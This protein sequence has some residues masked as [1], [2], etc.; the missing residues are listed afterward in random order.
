MTEGLEPVLV[1]QLIE[2]IVRQAIAATDAEAGTVWLVHSDRA[3][4][5]PAAAFGPNSKEI[6]DFCL[7]PGEG[8][9]G[10][11]IGGRQ[12]ILL[13][14]ASE[15]PAWAFYFD[16]FSGFRT[17]SV[18]CVPLYQGETPVGA[19]QLLNK[20][21]GHFTREDLV[22]ARGLAREVVALIKRGP[23]NDTGRA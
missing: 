21:G 14:E 9:V 11:A 17:G 22:L 5:Y 2:T 19:L 20:R 6:T 3:V 1:K 10:R 13:D 15:D 16:T 8:I 12:E 4:I 18:L 23:V 7:K